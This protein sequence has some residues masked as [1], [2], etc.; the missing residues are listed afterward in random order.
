MNLT[1]IAGQVSRDTDLNTTNLLK[2]NIQ[3]A[4]GQAELRQVK[5]DQLEEKQ[6]RQRLRSELEAIQYG[7]EK[8]REVEELRSQV[9]RLEHANEV[10]RDIAADVILDRS[11]IMKAMLAVTAKRYNSAQ[12]DQFKSEFDAERMHEKRKIEADDERQNKAYQMVDD[13]HIGWA[14]PSSTRRRRPPGHKP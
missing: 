9:R 7:Q 13:V 8:A 11:S 6:Q 5:Q 1:D 12:A 4:E 10:L 14:H 2:S 3:F